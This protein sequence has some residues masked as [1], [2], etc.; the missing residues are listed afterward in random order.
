MPVSQLSYSEILDLFNSLS[1]IPGEKHDLENILV[2]SKQLGHPEKK[3][4]SIHVAGTNGKGSVSLKIA[5][6][7]EFSGYRCGLFTSPHIS[8]FRERIKIGNELIP[9][10]L[11]AK[12]LSEIIEISQKTQIPLTYFEYCTLL[13]FQY[14][15]HAQVDLAVIEVGLGGRLDATNIIHPLATVITSISKDHTELLGETEELI[16]EEK[17]GTIKPLTPVIVGPRTPLAVFEAKA[18]LARAPLIALKERSSHYGIENKLI[19]SKAIDLLKDHFTFKPEGVERA[20]NIE[21][22]CRFEKVTQE[23]LANSNYQMRATILLDVAHNPDGID[24]LIKRL[25][26]AYPKHNYHFAVNFSLKKDIHR[27]VELL[28]SVARSIYLVD[29]GHP[30]LTTSD[31]IKSYFS[32][33]SLPIYEGTPEKTIREASLKLGADDIFIVCGSF[34][35]MGPIRSILG[36]KDTDD[37]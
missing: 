6:A 13:A 22:S 19:A 1:F 27:C 14:F 25:Q 12:F 20:L 15:A 10:E 4:R 2:I 16:A 31:Q 17:A 5:K 33:S 3:F 37:L 30:R 8:N 23:T 34:F 21:P 9:K 29:V 24:Q 11:T 32:D 18:A 26:Q 36:Y 7:L 28:T 35:I